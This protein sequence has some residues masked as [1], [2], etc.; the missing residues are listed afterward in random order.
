VLTQTRTHPDLASASDA[1][2]E[3]VSSPLLLRILATVV[4]FFNGL[5]LDMTTTPLPVA[6]FAISALLRARVRSASN[7]A[8]RHLYREVTRVF[9]LTTQLKKG[10]P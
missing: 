4:A 6:T 2:P 1:Q 7:A 9:P 10:N 3:F 5:K 8:M